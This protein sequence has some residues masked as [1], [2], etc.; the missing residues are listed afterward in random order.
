[1]DFWPWP[2]PFGSAA[3]RYEAVS[4]QKLTEKFNGETGQ[5]VSQSQNSLNIRLFCLNFLFWPSFFYDGYCTTQLCL[6]L[7]SETFIILSRVW[8]DRVLSL[9][10][11][12]RPL[13]TSGFPFSFLP[14]LT[15]LSSLNRAQL[16]QRHLLRDKWRIKIRGKNRG[17]GVALITITG[18]IKKN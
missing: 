1:M 7:L 9:P 5:T 11:F 3:S 12:E 10:L 18:L 4:N 16:R 2:L 13:F 14:T 17:F 15:P 8:D 6:T